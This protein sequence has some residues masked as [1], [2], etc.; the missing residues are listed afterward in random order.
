MKDL[1][2]TSRELALEYKEVAEKAGLEKD[3]IRNEW[4]LRK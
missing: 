4:L 2:Y 3:R 1:P